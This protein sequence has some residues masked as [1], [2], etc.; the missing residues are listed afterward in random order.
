MSGTHTSSEMYGFVIEQHRMFCT[1]LNNNRLYVSE[2]NKTKLP[3]QKQFCLTQRSGKRKL[4]PE[5]KKTTIT[6]TTGN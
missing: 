4:N 5:G 1:C 6:R 2:Q 3:I